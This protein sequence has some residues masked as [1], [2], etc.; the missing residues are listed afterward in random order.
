MSPELKPPSPAT[1]RLAVAAIITCVLYFGFDMAADYAYRFAS[2]AQYSP[3]ETFHLIAEVISV[4]L[5]IFAIHVLRG[6]MRFL[7]QQHQSDAQ[8]L[9]LLRGHFE[10][11]IAAKFDE[12]NLSAAER[13]VTLLIL[14]GMSVAAIAAARGTASGTVKAQSTAIFRKIGVGSKSEL[15]SLFMDEFLDSTSAGPASA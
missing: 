12:W 10:R 8:T 15:L 11:V 1:L 6:Q 5:M 4:L 13:D 3:V 2:G 9:S 7:R 14:K